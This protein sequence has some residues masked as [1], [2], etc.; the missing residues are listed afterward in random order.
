VLKVPLN[1]NHIVGKVTGIAVR[2]GQQR[3]P[4]LLKLVR[5][6]HAKKRVSMLQVS[7]R[8]GISTSVE[9]PAILARSSSRPSP[10]RY[11]FPSSSTP[12]SGTQ[13][14]YGRFHIACA[15]WEL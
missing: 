6:L 12:N 1:P 10:T 7:A 11:A 14:T 9:K 13:V 2:T 4:D 3:L 5:R 15:P 8:L